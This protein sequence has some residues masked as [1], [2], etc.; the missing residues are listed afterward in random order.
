MSWGTV[1]WWYWADLAAETLVT[2]AE[3][4]GGSA[5]L[6]ISLG[7]GRAPDDRVAAM[8]RAGAT[9]VP[10]ASTW[11]ALGDAD[12]FVT[13]Q[14]PNS[15]HEAI[16][17]RVPMLSYP[18]HGDQPGVA[19]F[20]AEHG[21]AVSLVDEP[22]APLTQEAVV[23]GVAQIAERRAQ[24]GEALE[25]ARGWELEVIAARGSVIDRVLAFAEA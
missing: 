5:E 22:L 19:A 8:G 18:F 10:Y 16:Y 1:P 12:I 14:G 3:S 13:A 4:L 11:D 2:V 15:S 7:G 25:R 23:A 20:C 21:L 9:V 24:F 17:S 6:L